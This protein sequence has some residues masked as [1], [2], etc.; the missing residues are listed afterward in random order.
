[1]VDLNDLVVDGPD[2]QVAFAYTINDRGEIA[3]LGF[4]PNG[5]E[6]AVLL[7]PC[8]KGDAVCPNE[9][10]R[11]NVRQ[12]SVLTRSSHALRISQGSILG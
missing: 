10:N 3:G 1:M 6:H 4:L 12:A 5:D 7:I 8:D 2:I 9:R 11:V